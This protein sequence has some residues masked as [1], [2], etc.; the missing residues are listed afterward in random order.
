M[1]TVAMLVILLYFLPTMVAFNRHHHQ[2]GAIFVLNVFLGW[3][4]LGWIVAANTA[5]Q[6]EQA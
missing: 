6:Q 4:F 1:A 5:E 3:T 2:R